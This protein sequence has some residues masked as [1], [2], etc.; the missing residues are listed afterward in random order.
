MKRILLLTMIIL[1]T[2]SFSSCE[3]ADWFLGT[4]YPIGDKSINVTLTVDQY[5]D[6]NAHPVIVGLI[7]LFLIDEATN[8]YQ[9][10]VN[11]IKTET[12]WYQHNITWTF[13][14]LNPNLY[15]VVA[16]YDFD[17]N[18]TI[19]QGDP[20]VSLEYTTTSSVTTQYFDFSKDNSPPSLNANGTLNWGSTI[21]P[22]LLGQLTGTSSGTTYDLTIYVY[23]GPVSGYCDVYLR[24]NS[25]GNDLM[26]NYTYLDA[27]G[28]GIVYF[29]GIVDPSGATQKV[30]LYFYDYNWNY[31][32][33]RT[34]TLS[35][36]L[37]GMQYQY[38]Y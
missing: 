5:M 27:S 14:G 35:G 7:P 36:D 16:F 2:F 10:D 30:D 15:R 9:I 13:G 22:S 6:V 26:Y 34:I 38:S 1:V 12:F 18:G 31:Q 24:D 25:S 17:N 37:S 21:D 23:N 20:A 11:K 4:I 3:I 19:N 33:Q 32:G 28:Y 8:K 29:W